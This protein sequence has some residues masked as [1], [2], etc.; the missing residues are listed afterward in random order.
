MYKDMRVKYL[1]IN[2]RYPVYVKFQGMLIVALVIAALP[3]FLYFK[4]SPNWMLKN[5]WWVLLIMVG[6]E[7]VETFLAIGKAKR[8]FHRPDANDTA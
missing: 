5:V 1:F 6:L 4:D 2:M 3:S 7:I 8:D